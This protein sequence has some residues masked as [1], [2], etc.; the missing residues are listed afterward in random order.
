MQAFY[1]DLVTN[2]AENQEGEQFRSKI[3]RY[4]QTEIPI[5]SVA[6]KETLH[7][8]S[9]VK[10]KVKEKQ[11]VIGILKDDME[12]PRRAFSDVGASH[13]P[14]VESAKILPTGSTV[15]S[16]KVIYTTGRTKR[17]GITLKQMLFAYYKYYDIET[18]FY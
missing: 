11:Q 10:T 9:T 15:T 2:M 4:V 8:V 17:K 14:G 12:V 7:K 1:S 3:P 13:L 18:D 16:R 6:Y 5:C